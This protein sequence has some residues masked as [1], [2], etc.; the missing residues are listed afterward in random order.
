[1]ENVSIVV[2]CDDDIFSLS[3]G[4]VLFEC[5]NGYKAIII[6][7]NMS[8]LDALRKTIM[9]VIKGCNI[10]LIFLLSTYLCR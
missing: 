7:E 5:L 10:L 6:S 2:Y 8:S 4:M 9:N 3:E 1:M